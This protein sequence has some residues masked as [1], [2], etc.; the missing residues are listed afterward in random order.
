MDVLGAARP[1]AVRDRST[2]DGADTRALQD[3][4]EFRERF[5]RRSF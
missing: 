4:R 1:S 5:H 2:Q 3:E